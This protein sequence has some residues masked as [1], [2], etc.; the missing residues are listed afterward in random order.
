MRA[1][2]AGRRC[3]TTPPASVPSATSRLTV[4][5]SG[6][7]RTTTLSGSWLACTAARSSAGEAPDTPI[8]SVAVETFPAKAKPRMA[9]MA[10]GATRQ[11]ITAERSRTRRRS[12]LKVMTKAVSRR[13]PDPG[14]LSSPRKN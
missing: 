11:V 12:S 14:S 3:R 7:S 8:G 6:T 9:A 2:C 1:A 4:A 5:S 13:A 10:S